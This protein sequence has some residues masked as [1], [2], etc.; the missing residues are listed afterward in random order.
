MMV[1]QLLE[2]K[3]IYDDH[4]GSTKGKGRQRLGKASQK[5]GATESPALSPGRAEAQSCLMN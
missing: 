3:V 2:T 1:L 5:A 4:K